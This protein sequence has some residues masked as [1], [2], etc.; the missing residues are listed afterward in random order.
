[1]NNKARSAWKAP[2]LIAAGIVIG[3]SG[4]LI[5]HQ[6]QSQSSTPTGPLPWPQTPMGLT[7]GAAPLVMLVASRDHKLF[8]EA[9]NDTTDLNGDGIIDT[10]F[11]PNITYLGLFNSR[12]CYQ[13]G[14]SGSSGLFTPTGVTSNGKC[15]GQWSGNWLNYVTTSRIDAL[16]VVLYGGYRESDTP[17]ETILRRAYIPQDAHSWA[18]EYTSPAV[19]GYDISDYTPLSQPASGRRH[20]FGNLTANANT[21]CASIDNC[22]NL[23]P[24]LRVVTNS[25]KRVWEWASKERPVLDGTHGGTLAD[26]TVRVRVCQAPYTDGCRQYPNGYYKPIGILH[27]YGEMQQVRFGLLTG[28]YDKNMSGGVL[29]KNIGDFSGEVNPVTGQFTDSATIVRT[30]DRLRIRDFNNGRTDTAYRSGWSAAGRMMNEGEF[31]DWGNPIG[32]MLY[33]A[34]RYFAGKGS[35]TAAFDTSGGHDGALGLP[36]AASWINPYTQTPDAA[37]CSKAFNLVLSDIHPSFDSDQVPGSAFGG[38]AGD[39]SGFS[40]SWEANAISSHEPGVP[41]LRF[42]GEAPDSNDG[43]PSPKNV[44][45]LANIRGLAPEEPGKRGSYYSASAAY[46]AKRT[47]LQSL[48]GRQSVDTFVVALSSPLPTIQ[49]PINAGSSTRVITIAPFAKSVG[50]GGFGIDYAGPFQPTNQ[51]VDFYVETVRNVPGFPSDP[52]INGGRPYYKFLINF[53]DIEWGGDHDMD[54]IAQYEVAL[55]ADNT[56]RV[57]VTP[58]YQAGGIMQNMGYVISGTTRDGVYLVVSDEPTPNLPY[59]LN[60]PPGRSAG[61][62]NP[63]PANSSDPRWNECANLPRLGGSPAF[64]EQVF[65]A[66][67]S[68]ASMLK[69]PLWFAAKWGAFRDVNGNALPDL[70][71]EWD[72]NN[73]GVPDAYLF[74]HN[75]ARLRDALRQALD[76]IVASSRAGAGTAAT[77]SFVDG[78]TLVFATQVDPNNWSGDLY[79][80]RAVDYAAGTAGAPV[81]RASQNVPSPTSRRIWSSWGGAG[82]QFL[83]SA[84]PTAVQTLMISEEV[85]NYLR[86]DRSRELRNGGTFRNRPVDNVLGTFLHSDTVYVRDNG[87]VCAGS[88]DGMVHCFDGSSGAERF[89]YIPSSALARMPLLSLPTTQHVYTMDGALTVTTRAETTSSVWSGGRN[90]LVGTPGRGGRGLFAIDVTNPA[91]FGAGSILW[92][93][94]NAEDNDLGYIM[95]KPVVIRTRGTTPG[96]GYPVVLVGNGYQS[97]N[98]KSV[99][100]VF[101][102]NDGTLLRKIDLG[103]SVGGLGSPVAVDIDGDGYT[104]TA[105]A[106]D[107]LGRVWKFDL[108]DANPANWRAAYGSPS[109]PA[110][111]FTTPRGSVG[112]VDQPITARPYVGV[113]RDASHPYNG[114]ALIIVGT[115]SYFRAS[116]ASDNRVQALYGLYDTGTPIGSLS[117]LYPVSMSATT[118]LGKPARVLNMVPASALSGKRG[119]YVNFPAGERV[120][121]QPSV[122]YTGAGDVGR[123]VTMKPSSDICVPGVSGFLNAFDPFRGGNFGTPPLD[124]DRDGDFMDEM[125][126]VGGSPLPVTSM[127]TS[128]PSAFSGVVTV[129]HADVAGELRVNRRRFAPVQRWREVLQ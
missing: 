71:E 6:A 2:W 11:N 35:P 112:A 33:E 63:R 36:R 70:Q 61:Y 60:V 119:W 92:D 113:V 14:G 45:T 19:D 91:S 28:S 59:H 46:F 30:F 129:G 74:V 16:R 66:G 55:N 79:A 23:P 121:T 29:R 13:Y 111:L 49:I 24:L 4:I 53:E 108:S 75:P 128:L 116:D 127:E 94:T 10:R 124:Y 98:G 82:F 103:G 97:T 87:L 15:Q 50:P 126:N 44:T 38:L 25:T 115:G 88:N 125:V 105:Y 52:S 42:I 83:W 104:E 32:E 31:V 102:L 7:A 54:A 78:G 85:V 26:Y 109:A 12:Y 68:G 27:E 117:D 90:I 3:L 56:V 96:S 48:P 5:A 9:Y 118:H 51:I 89:A 69:D 47:D 41:G 93:H 18:K 65:T 76:Q 86:G 40:A 80:F 72:A 34:A 81:W 100:Y 84:M 57:R 37:Y 95:D 114:K 123:V 122:I 43:T 21:N 64:S 58:T 99:L 22:S 8:Y 1:M 107:L 62:C 67:T 39:L 106:A 17:T 77:S 101:R 73:D 120:V 20:F 110:P